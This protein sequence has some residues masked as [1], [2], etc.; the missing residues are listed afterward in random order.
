MRNNCL[1]FLSA[2]R[3]SSSFFLACVTVCGLVLM[4]G[5]AARSAEPPANAIGNG[6][7]LQIT[8][9][10]E[11][12]VAQV[13]SGRFK[14]GTDG[15]ITYPIL[16]EVAVA[17]KAP[18]D[19][20][21]TIV[22]ALGRQVPISGIPTVSV[23]EYAPLYLLGSVARTGP[24]EYQPNMTVFQLILQVGGLPQPAVAGG[25][26][27]A[28]AAKVA[29]LEL[30]SFSLKVRR[31][32]LE[33]EVRDEPFDGSN[34]PAESDE[35]RARIVA[36]EVSLFEANLHALASQKKG[37]RAQIGTYDQEIDSLKKSI[38]LHDQELSLL[39]EQYATQE[40]L[41][42]RGLTPRSNLLD[43]QRQLTVA[44]R[45]ALDL[46]TALYRAQQG[47]LDVEQKLADAELSTDTQNY[48]ALSS[49][50]LE[51]GVALLQLDDARQHLAALPEGGGSATQGGSPFGVVATYTLTRRNEQGEYVSS[52]AT[53][54][55]LLKR[56]DILRVDLPVGKKES[57][58]QP[59]SAEFRPSSTVA[60]SVGQ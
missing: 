40:K 25:D 39:E 20:A 1:A 52:S 57:I 9:F 14:V 3:S 44:R 48:Q 12:T 47:R 22:Q 55:T 60:D 49:V 16:G 37:Y 58:A 26:R 17:G 34:L 24:I 27:L 4:G 51:L 35:D 15:T 42:D 41:A 28:A 7:V 59:A 18:A 33:A 45:E 53:E 8:V 10:G 2:I 13:L 31:A 29:Q 21:Q 32:R 30:Q 56:G 43:M 46:D 19:V 38:D 6:D 50:E 36:D 23:A 5:H 11:A 54:D